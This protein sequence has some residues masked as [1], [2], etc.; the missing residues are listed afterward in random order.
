MLGLLLFHPQHHDQH[1][2]ELAAPC[3]ALFH[4]PCRTLPT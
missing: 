4:C 1:S 2:K 3:P